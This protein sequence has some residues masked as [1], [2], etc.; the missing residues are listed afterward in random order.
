MKSVKLA[1]SDLYNA[2]DLM[3]VDIVEK[4][5]GC[6][7]V[8]TK[9]YAA[10][11]SA[12]GGALFGLQYSEDIKQKLCQHILHL[13]YDKKP[14]IIWG[15]GFWHDNNK[16]KLFRNNLDVRAL[17]G[18]KS[19]QKLYDLTGTFYDV[20][21]ADGGLLIDQLFDVQVKKE[22]RMGLILHMYHQDN[23]IIKKI[24]DR[25]DINIINIKQPPANVGIEIA[26]CETIIS[27]SLHGLVFSDA[28]HVPNLHISI[29]KGLPEGNFKF[30]DYYSSYGLKDNII[31][32]NEFIPTPEDIIFRYNINCDEVEL[33]KKQLIECFPSL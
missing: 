24:C 18:A 8:R 3:N 10:E 25:N 26:K 27:S 4:L 21:L 9:T 11:M 28:L 7:V 15:S 31:D 1:Y 13:F 12:I 19:Q 33:K 20:P 5:S 30:E 32:I 22:Y 6:K 29:G 2:G 16:S 14:I 23:D 17:R